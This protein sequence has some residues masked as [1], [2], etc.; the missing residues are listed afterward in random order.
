MVL[1]YVL[2]YVHVYYVPWYYSSTMVHVYVPGTRV[3]WYV[4][5]YYQMVEY[6]WYEYVEYPWYEY[7]HVYSESTSVR[8]TCTR[9]GILASYQ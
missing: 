7:V 4:H 2:G 8:T 1:E 6:P 3:P 5:M 9:Y